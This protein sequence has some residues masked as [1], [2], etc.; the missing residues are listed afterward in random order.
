MSSE[1]PLGT[2]SFGGVARAVLPHIS[3]LQADNNVQPALCTEE[4]TEIDPAR[5]LRRAAFL[6]LRARPGA[7]GSL[8]RSWRPGDSTVRTI[9]HT[10]AC[11]GK[12]VPSRDRRRARE[13]G[14][15]SS[16]RRPRRPLGA[17]QH[18]RLRLQPLEPRTNNQPEF[19]TP[20]STECCALGT[21]P[22][23]AES[24]GDVGASG[25]K[26]ER[27]RRGIERRERFGHDTIS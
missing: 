11:R 4:R 14:R 3:G 25:A 5:A 17:S 12:L 8:G 6:D 23:S 2:P 18:S 15:V 24:L 21:S 9:A 26:A 27:G 13:P 10:E 16:P 20:S 22:K 19:Q 7:A 1:R